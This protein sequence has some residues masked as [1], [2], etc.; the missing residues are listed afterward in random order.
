MT[1]T[2]ILF[3]LQ[4]FS[5]HDGPGVRTTV[6]LKG[7]ALRCAW[8]HNPESRA[9]L[10]ELGYRADACQACGSCVPAC[11]YGAHQMVD[12][13]HHLD[14]DVCR[15]ADCARL[16][17]G[18]PPCVAV[19]PHGALSVAGRRVTV[20]E[21]MAEVERDRA[22][23]ARSGGGLT[24]SGGEPLAQAGFVSEL[25][26]AA[27]GAGIHT[28]VETAG[29]VPWQSLDRVRPWVDLW[30]FDLKASHPGR[31]RELTGGRLDPI[32]A[33]LNALYAYEAKILVRCPLVPGVNDDD[34]HLAWLADFRAGHPEL[35]GLEVMAYHN[36][37]NAKYNRYGWRN[38]LP[39][40]PSA[41]CAEQT[42]W[43][44]AL[45]L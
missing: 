23:Y 29:A 21:V 18:R 22:Y 31:H 40:L 10:P 25:L 3:D 7:C 36:L 6:F 14:R 26:Q 37:G 38:P 4:R 13:R 15:T 43:Q 35:V 9:F 32:L 1:I 33:N 39:D 17:E 34:A 42:R 30:L 12:G 24:I 19:C 44:A 28:C 8:C 45:G 41:G 2:G 5:L 20:A 27:R 16:T 11:S